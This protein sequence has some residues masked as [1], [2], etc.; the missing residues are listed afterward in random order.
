MISDHGALV[1]QGDGQELV[2]ASNRSVGALY[3]SIRHDDEM[4]YGIKVID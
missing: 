3:G 4:Y 2:E 1:F